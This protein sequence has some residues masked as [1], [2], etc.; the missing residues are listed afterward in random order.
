MLESH[1]KARSYK[2]SEKR[3]SPIF[4]VLKM[5]EVRR[6]SKGSQ[7]KICP[8]FRLILDDDFS[9]FTDQLNRKVRK[10]KGNERK[11]IFCSELCA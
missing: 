4:R 9:I 5:G 7:F 2:G 1:A 3:P 10:G 6:G 8:A 11:G